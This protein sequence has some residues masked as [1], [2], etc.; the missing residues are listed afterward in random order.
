MESWNER[1]IMAPLENKQKFSE[2]RIIFLIFM[3]EITIL[4]LL[5]S[6]DQLVRQKM[7]NDENGK[8]KTP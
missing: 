8:P 5:T 1:E 4:T 2:K 7:T 3:V 6:A